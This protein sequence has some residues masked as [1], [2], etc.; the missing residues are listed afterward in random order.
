MIPKRTW[1]A[2]PVIAAFAALAAF[3]IASPTEATLTWDPTLENT[4]V[5]S[6]TPGANADITFKTDI[7]AVT[8]LL[9]S[10]GLELPANSWDIASDGGVPNGQ[11]TAVGTMAVDK[12]CNGSVET[13][14]PFSLADQDAGT[15]GSAPHAIWS[16]TITDFGD[17]NPST[18]WTLQL[19]V[20]GDFSPNGFSIDG[21]M[22][23]AFGVSLCTPQTFTITFCGRANPNGAATVCGSGADPVVMTNPAS[24]EVYTWTGS[25]LDET[26]AHQALPKAPVCIG[27]S[28]GSTLFLRDSNTSGAATASDEM[29]DLLLNRGAASVDY[30]KDTVGGPVTPPTAATQFTKVAGGTF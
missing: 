28:C 10:Y 8:H 9:G 19:I 16:G 18:F 14:G 24:P 5:S 6:R 12:D 22:T 27:T 13:Y 15:G 7:L 26:T 1:V 23:D 21:I 3:Y 25:L 11:V 29:H 2:L 30:V 20:D 17:G 4:A